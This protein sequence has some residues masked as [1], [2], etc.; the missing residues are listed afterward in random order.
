MSEEQPEFAMP[1]LGSL[2]RK[3]D[4][5]WQLA[6]SSCNRHGKARFGAH[7]MASG[8]RDQLQDVPIRQGHASFS[9]SRKFDNHILLISIPLSC[10]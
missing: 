4:G 7:V 9:D 2:D 3:A 5:A 1:S 8:G 6:L 10:P